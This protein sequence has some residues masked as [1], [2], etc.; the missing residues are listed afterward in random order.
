MAKVR[1]SANIQSKNKSGSVGEKSLKSQRTYQLGVVYKD[2]YGRETPVFTN[3]DASFTVPKRLC[4]K[5][6][7]IITNLKSDI[8]SWVDTFKFFVK[9]TSNEYYNACMDRWYDAEDGNIW[10]SFPSAERNKIK[11]EG[12]I[13][14]KKQ[15]GLGGGAVYEEA[16][17]KVIDIQNEAP[18][19]VKTDYEM[20]GTDTVRVQINGALPGGKTIKFKETTGSNGWFDSVFYDELKTGVSDTALVAGETD[21]GF[22]G[23]P[24]EDVVIR[25]SNSSGNSATEWLDVANIYKDAD[26]FVELSKTLPG[27]NA[28]GDPGV[29]DSIIPD[30]GNPKDVVV[31]IAKKVTKNKSEFDGKFFVKISRDTT[32]NERIRSVKTGTPNITIKHSI[33]QYYIDRDSGMSSS[34]STNVGWADSFWSDFAEKWFIDK[35]Q[36]QEV[37]SQTGSENYKGPF[38]DHDGFGIEGDGALGRDAA[39]PFDHKAE[40]ESTLELTLNKI[41]DFDKD[42]YDISAQKDVNQKV[43]D[44][45]KKEG[46]MFRWKEDPFQHIYKITRAVDS[47]SGVNASSSYDWLNGLLNYS[48][49]KHDRKIPENKAIRLYLNFKTTGWRLNLDQSNASAVYTFYPKDEAKYPFKYK[50]DYDNVP[51]YSG[52][53]DPWDPTKRG[54]GEYQTALGEPEYNTAGSYPSLSSGSWQEIDSGGSAGNPN[55]NPGSNAY[56]FRNTLEIVEINPGEQ[57]DEFTEEPAIWE[58]EPREDVGLDIYYEASQAYP[59]NLN[60][61]TNELFAPYGCVVTSNDVIRIAPVGG[62]TNDWALHLPDNT[63]LYDWAPTGHGGD[64]ILLNINTDEIGILQPLFPITQTPT[65]FNPVNPGY[66]NTATAFNLMNNFLVANG[67]KLRFTRI[68]GSYTT[69]K[70]SHIS[71]WYN[72]VWDQA[73]QTYTTSPNYFINPSNYIGN[74]TDTVLIKLDRDLSKMNVKLP[75]FNCYSFGNGVESDRIRDDF[76]A[77]RLD[78]GVKVSTVL[79]EPYDEEQ[80]TNGLIYSGLYNST[81]GVN[82]LNQFI[83]AETITKDVNPSYGSIQKLKTR[84]TNLVAFC[85]DKILK[86]VA[87]KDAL[88]N[89]DG[90]PQLIASNKVLGNVTTFAGEFGISKNPESYAEDSFRMYCTDK[91]RGKVLRISGDGITAISDYGMQDYFADNLKKND[92]LLGSF[93]D[94]KQEYNLTLKNNTPRSDSPDVTISFSEAAKGWTS[95]KSFIQD[96]GLSLNNEYYTVKEG[97]L[98]RHHNDSVDRNTFYD[99]W[100]PSHVDVL[101][102]EESATVKSFASMKYEGTQGK[103]TQNLTDGEYYNNENT[104][105]I[106][107][108]L[109]KQ[110]WYV[111]SGITDLQEAGEM[112]FK[113][114]EGKW[115]SYMK[116]KP[117]AGAN[118]LDSKEFSFQGIDLLESIVDNGGGGGSVI[119]GCTDPSATNYDPLA[120]IDDGSCIIPTYGCTDPNAINYDPTATQDDGSCV[121]QSN[122]FTITVQDIGDEDNPIILGCTDP[123]AINYDPTATADDGSCV[124]PVSGC[125]D[126][127]ATNYNPL[128]TIDD[129][130]CVYPNPCAGINP[131]VNMSVTSGAYPNIQVTP[132]S[133]A[134]DLPYTFEL[135][136]NPTGYIM[137]PN[138][139]VGVGSNHNDGSGPSYYDN[140]IQAGQY[141]LNITTDSGCVFLDTNSNISIT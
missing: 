1:I 138:T 25:L 47:S 56:A 32:I 140:N 68:D 109:G 39:G 117:V 141:T 36:R 18:D 87:N 135:I 99:D 66:G 14:L 54:Y 101:F 105:T 77:V 49:N 128:A 71:G 86:I 123:T 89:A 15:S 26:L 6:N 107:G 96:N 74:S 12:F 3:S 97:V 51:T 57:S 131:S 65:G 132:T 8:P 69:A 115:F 10:L 44:K 119:S 104:S 70:I 98:W 2:I 122:S 120:T 95:F 85:E 75:Y 72:G 129:G 20:Y 55:W 16:R 73:L 84:D 27:I 127:T 38:Y 139:N 50:N 11:E 133:S 88:Y 59:K 33:D 78:K 62:T 108:F 113:N 17:Y 21:T 61:K 114:K 94:R 64:T 37:G 34:N 31:K 80:R 4:D 118:D 79:D 24:L 130:S 76:N 13:V 93:D 60:N 102:N 91:Q 9:E 23:W 137:I 5:R 48:S 7:S 40:L 41:W 58:T 124:Y 106:P 83:A 121:Y 46:T 112:E 29:M 81:S 67:L 63:V 103:I 100:T 82:N 30:S 43:L 22:I 52:A 125:T 53:N 42:G 92:T 136:H 111:E 19:F 126:S 116:G 90:N 28:D 110:G 35:A 45:L 134:Q